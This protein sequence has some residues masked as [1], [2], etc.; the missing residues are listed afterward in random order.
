MHLSQVIEDYRAFRDISPRT[1][2]DYRLAVSG[3]ETWHKR[4]IELDTLKPAL[5]N[6][7]LLWLSEIGQS[8]VTVG[9]RRTKILVVWRAACE[10]GLTENWPNERRIRKVKLPRPNPTCW[11]LD[12]IRNVLA[13][14][15]S[16]MRFPLRSVNVMAGDYVGALIR[17][18]HD[19]GMR[20]GDAV[21]MEFDWV[22]PGTVTWAQH[23][24]GVWHR[25]Q[26]TPETLAAIKK[27]RTDDRRLIWPRR[28]TDSGAL[29]RL[30]R[31][32]AIGAGV[33]GTSKFIR[34][35]GATDVYRQG[36]DPAKYC[37]HAP[38]S[39]VAVYWYVSRDAQIDPVS[40]TKI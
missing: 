32:A 11:T 30:V 39:R 37:G 4:P 21:S 12:D 31:T 28:R 23:K 27:I 25:A 13:Y 36:K 20:I 10:L 40:P 8:P 18:L 5:L 19:S 7:Y 2:R 26:L 14:C 33:D 9:G 3:F 38:G 15:E 17:F 6:Q 16:N 34:R 24:T 35:G 29:Y 1:L 22:L